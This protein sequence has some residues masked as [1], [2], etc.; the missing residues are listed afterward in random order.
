MGWIADK[1]FTKWLPGMFPKPLWYWQ[2]CTVAQEDYF[3][4]NAT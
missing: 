1:A 4:G 2:K 3:E